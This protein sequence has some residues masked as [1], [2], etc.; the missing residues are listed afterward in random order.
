MN[1][2]AVAST[3]NAPEVYQEGIKDISL[4]VFEGV[5]FLPGTLFVQSP[6]GSKVQVQSSAN[7]VLCSDFGFASTAVHKTAEDEQIKN[8]KRKRIG[9]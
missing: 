2:A 1:S 9:G 5:S 8:V 6:D 7:R 3:S 4:T